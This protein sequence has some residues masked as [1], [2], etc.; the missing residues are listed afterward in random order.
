LTVAKTGNIIALYIDG[1]KITQTT[2]AI[3]FPSD[4]N[5]VFFGSAVVGTSQL[6]PGSINEVRI[7]NRAL[8]DSEI[9]AL[10]NAT[11]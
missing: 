11:K 3:N 7:Y 6:F 5:E 10:Y 2:D 8:S 4:S 1:I 9:S